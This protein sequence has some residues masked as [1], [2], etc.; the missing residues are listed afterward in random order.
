MNRYQELGQLISAWAEGQTVK[1]KTEDG[2][3]ELTPDNMHAQ[4]SD[5]EWVTLREAV[6]R[7]DE[8]KS[9]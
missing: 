1:M 8:R 9:S 5:K 2:W 7:Y 6:A 4:T 3:V